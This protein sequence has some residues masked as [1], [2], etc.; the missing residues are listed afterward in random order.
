[1]DT[2][3]NKAVIIYHDPCFDGSG[4]AYIAREKLRHAVRVDP[5]ILYP[6]TYGKEPPYELCIGADAYILDFS[7]PLEQLMELRKLT[8]CLVL[9]DHHDGVEARIASLNADQLTT[10]RN[11]YFKFDETKSGVGLAWDYFV[12]TDFTKAPRILQAIQDRDLWRFALPYTKHLMAGL[13]SYEISPA[14]ITNLIAN[15]DVEEELL[16]AGSAL[17]R[18]EAAHIKMILDAGPVG[19]YADNLWKRIPVY[20]CPYWLVSE[21]G[22]IVASSKNAFCICYSSSAKGIKYSL[23]SVEGG[24]NVTA[25]AKEFGGGGHKNGHTAG[26]N[27]SQADVD[28]FWTDRIQLAK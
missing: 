16:I 28:Y 1:M 26:I 2:Q 17:L 8:A 23:R 20:N 18:Q 24:A 7:Y 5:I 6:A 14:T 3:K 9:L 22:N 21:L 19:Y 12:G 13:G 25:I 27:F 11:D 15:P 10:S 4:A